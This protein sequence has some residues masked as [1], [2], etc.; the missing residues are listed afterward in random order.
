M[1]DL[2]LGTQDAIPQ[3]VGKREWGR[4]LARCLRYLGM[5]S[6]VVF[7]TVLAGVYA[8]IW[9][10]NLGGFADEMRRDDIE[11]RVMIGLIGIGTLPPG[12]RDAIVQQALEAAYAAADLDRPFFLRSF[13][14]F[15]D[16]FT[17][18]LGEARRMRSTRGSD[19][20]L[21]ILS[22]RLPLTV[23]LFGVA[24]IL[25]FFGGLFIALSLSRRYGSFLDRAATLLVPAFAAPSWFHGLFL[26]VI[27]ALLA[28]VLPFGGIVG[29]PL[30]E[31]TL[32]YVLSFLKHMILPVSALVLGTM[33]HAV[34][35]NRALFLIHSS[36]DYV[37]LAEAKGLRSGRL[38]TRY[39]LRPVLPA[40]ITNF[41]LVSIVSWQA[42][43]LTEIVFRWP[44]LGELLIHAI[45]TH[46]VSVVIGAVTIFAY[47]LGLTVLLLDF[48]YVLVDPRVTLGGGRRK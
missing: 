2:N 46:E 25:T 40:I 48:L 15:R 12:E 36:E 42:V 34:Y 30:P 10:T 41:A 19:D 37:D 35:A 43:I 27:F 24:N 7:V 32:G 16:A 45:Y 28:K 23:V 20:V 11:H 21:D 9:V 26:I 8:A 44:G 33:P 5:R 1:S 39:I 18:S 17:L 3:K 22:E 6:I 13:G 38:R 4:T 47:L 31:T 29:V 14:Y